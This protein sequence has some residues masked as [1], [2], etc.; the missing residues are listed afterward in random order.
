[1]REFFA[2]VFNDLNTLMR[3]EWEENS[4]LDNYALDQKKQWDYL[5]EKNVQFLSREELLQ[6]CI[7]TVANDKTDLL[8]HGK[9]GSGKSTLVS[10]IGNIL[11]QK[12]VDIVPIYCGYSNLTTSGFDIMQY[13]IYEIERRLGVEEHFSEMTDTEETKKEV[14]VSYMQQLF[15]AYST[16][17]HRDIVFLIDGIDQLPQD[18]FAKDYSF[19][20][21]H[22]YPKKKKMKVTCLN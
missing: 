7:A 21:D 4:T 3:K 5:E 13:I 15:D 14:W 22:K 2:M 1:M 16:S 6:Q 10:R 11:S 9:T 12:G 20:P 18:R 8:I 19:I 17:G